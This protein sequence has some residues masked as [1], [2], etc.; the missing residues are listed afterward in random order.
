MN[1]NNDT[2]TSVGDRFIVFIL[3]FITLV[4]FVIV[5]LPSVLFTMILT[6]VFINI[7]KISKIYFCIASFVLAI[8]VNFKVSFIQKYLVHSINFLNIILDA[9]IHKK[10][11]TLSTL[12]KNYIININ[13]VWQLLIALI[14]SSII[15]EI[16]YVKRQ[17]EKKGKSKTEKRKENEK[18]NKINKYL[19]KINLQTHD[20]GTT[21]IGADYE[22]IKTVK[23]NDNAKHIIV[24]GTT[25]AGKTIAIANFIESA[26]QKNH[27]VFA[28][29]GKGDLGD[30]S[31]LNYMQSLSETYNRQ[32]YVVNFVKPDE[33]DHYNPFKGAGMTEAKDMLI[34]MS[35]WS[36]AHY[37]VN[38]ERYL[39]QLIKILNIKKIPLDLNTIIKYSPTLF[40]NLIEEMKDNNEIGIGE[41]AKLS[42]IIETT[43]PIVNS[44]MARFAT[45]S[46][47][48]A[49]EIFNSN[50]VDVYTALKQK[51]NILIILDSLGKPELS[52]QVGRLAILDAK[53]AVSKLFLDKTRKYFIFDEFNV[54]ASDVAID[55]LNKSRSANITC[56]PAFQSLSDLDK[57]GGVALRNQVIENCNN[58]IIMRQNSYDSSAE[59]EKVIGQEK[60]TN[61][62]YGVEKKASIFGNKIISTGNGNMH[63]TMQSKYTYTDIQNL[64]TG[65]SIFISK[66]QKIDTKMKMR[67]VKVNGLVLEKKESTKI[68]LDKT[69]PINPVA[70]VDIKPEYKKSEENEETSFDDI[71]N[72]LK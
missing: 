48:E 17:K 66:D 5:S 65:Q 29:D 54:Y 39:Q 60:R 2:N 69:A 23:I 26:M 68:D 51:A 43:A 45:T 15:A 46:E 33:S 24:A 22:N 58:Y 25:G 42:D 50:G 14:L 59:W 67:Y 38:T 9:V 6:V 3:A 30:G 31:L 63:E 1:N 21:T 44:A 36:E 72:L 52:K 37:K 16:Y 28:I 55:L 62:S 7:K 18:E 13:L 40:Q 10:T 70:P 53:K 32:L 47:S 27:P 61:Y 19:E 20:E 4:L 35:D 49:G 8:L 57:A 41:Y 34:G 12:Y 56:I 11:A 64:E 71:E